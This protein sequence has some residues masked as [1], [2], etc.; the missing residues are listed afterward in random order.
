MPFAYYVEAFFHKLF[1][2]NININSYLG[3]INQFLQTYLV[4]LILNIFTILRQIYLFAIVWI[5]KLYY[6]K[7]ASTERRPTFMPW[8]L[9]RWLSYFD[10]SHR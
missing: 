8:L 1:G 4:Y 3:L 5:H 7:Q 9:L 2:E 6:L 10:L